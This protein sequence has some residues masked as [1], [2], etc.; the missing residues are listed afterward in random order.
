MVLEYSIA[1]N[2]WSETLYADGLSRWS[3][4]HL[5]LNALSVVIGWLLQE[6]K[7]NDSYQSDTHFI[8]F[9]P[10]IS[11]NSS[12][13]PYYVL[14]DMLLNLNNKLTV[15]NEAKLKQ[16][17]LKNFHDIAL[18]C[19]SSM[20]AILERLMIVFFYKSMKKDMWGNV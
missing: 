1:Y 7:V 9:F 6:V 17:L 5:L 11:S 3:D 10:T 8:K 16:E 18:G 14:N 20:E 19:N 2:K 12:W 4:N 15:G 13:K